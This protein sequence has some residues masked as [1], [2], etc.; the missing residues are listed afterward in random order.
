[1]NTSEL[2]DGN[3][4]YQL[5]TTGYS[6]PVHMMPGK[7][8]AFQNNSDGSIM[9]IHQLVNAPITILVN[10]DDNDYAEGSLFLDQGESLSELNN[11]N[12]EYY[13]FLFSQKAL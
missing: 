10:P 8:I 11:R 1:M 3:R 7:I 12:F 5:D 2:L 6:T 4:T 9:N 13:N